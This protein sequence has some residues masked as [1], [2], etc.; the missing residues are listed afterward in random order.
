MNIDSC[1]QSIFRPINQKKETFPRDADHFFSF[2]CL[3]E[4]HIKS[5]I[6]KQFTF[7]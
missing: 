6:Q 5:V 1:Q 2:I 7:G 3:F 4:Q